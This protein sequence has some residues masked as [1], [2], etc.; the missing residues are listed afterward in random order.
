MKRKLIAIAILATLAVSVFSGCNSNSETPVTT[1][2]QPASQQATTSASPI[3][4]D[5][6]Y[7]TVYNQLLSDTHEF[8]VGYSEDAIPEEGQY[9]IFEGISGLDTDV[10]LMRVGYISQD[11]NEDSVPE[12]LIVAVNED[13]SEVRSGTRVLAAYTCYLGKVTLIFEGNSR[14]RYYILEDGTVYNEG[15]SG[16]AYS[17][18]ATYAL[19]ANGSSL[20]PKDYYFT[21][22]VS[23]GSQDIGYYHNT[24]GILDVSVSEQFT[25]TI[26]GFESKQ[27][28]LSK[29][30]RKFELT[31]FD[32]VEV[33][34][35]EDA[36]YAE[37]AEG[38]SVDLSACAEYSADE[39]EHSTTVIFRTDSQ[40]DDFKLLNL[41]YIDVNV[42]NVY[43][44]YTHG[45]LTNDKPLA[46]TLTLSGTIPNY[47]ISY[48]DENGNEVRRTVEIS[49][50]DG[51]L[52]LNEF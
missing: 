47:G 22:P 52:M 50:V 38:S 29:E 9:G 1:D 37:F 3:P 23:E 42:Y 39:T 18:F 16:A 28:E 17:I 48:T 31:S 7:S 33:V 5:V 25:D 34:E 10:A 30:I 49:G 14:N 24:Q 13:G 2:T 27:S 19:P 51:A 46:V 11:I 45:P 43:E 4:S 21:S 40:V 8:I 15:S 44:A 12:L 41:E 26:D 20:E 35:I 6:D 36:V 32:N